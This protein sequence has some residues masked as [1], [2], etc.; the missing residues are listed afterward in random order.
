[1]TPRE[2]VLA[3]IDHKPTDRTPADYGA[4]SGV[5]ERLIDTLGVAD[6]EELLRALGV[7]MRRVR[8]NHNQP[9][10]EP[11]D[12]GYVLN[13]WGAR[14]REGT[15]DDG[16]PNLISPFDEATTV[17]DVHAHAW[18]DPDALDY[19]GIRAECES[20][21]GEYAVYGSPWCPFFHEVGWLIGQENFFVWM[22]T[23][24]EVA[25]AIIER[26]VDY[27]VAVT[28]RFL[29][30]AGGLVDIAFF[31]NDYGTQRGPL[32]SPE[33]WNR[34]LR[35]EQKR[36]FDEAHDH[37]C[38]VMFHS[39]GSIR[40][41]LPAL[42]E[43]GVDVLDPVQTSA[44]G[45]GFDGLLADF[46]PRV[47]FHGGVDTQNTLPFGSAEDVRAEVRCFVE[48]TREAG[49]YILCGSQQFIEDIPLDN[50]LALYDEDTR[51]RV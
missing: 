11:D 3:A 39:C 12:A 8:L 23:K 35:G 42:I 22:A 24:P 26:V 29:Q 43:D 13:M 19:S 1:M 5:T 49:G 15:F 18:P 40:E 45:M 20:H 48:A 33:M 9:E 17:E 36:L 28:R 6:A 14:T 25:A 50:I 46:G 38:R 7:D 27:E 30:A 31:G 10:S 2:R 47:C 21:A 16:G 41:V 51:V 32:V 34:F 4:H 44:A 37:G